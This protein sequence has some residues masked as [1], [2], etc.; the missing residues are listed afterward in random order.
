MF[1]A[2][3]TGAVAMIVTLW[4][5]PAVAGDP[6]IA[7][8]QLKIGYTL[9]QEGKCAEAVAHL[10][11]SLRLD[12]K[13]I[14]LINLADCEEKVGKL[15]D[16]LGH[17]VDARMRARTEGAGPIEEEAERRAT[18][19]EPRLARL[20]IVL[21]GAA[22]RDA[23]VE[24]D[25]VVLGAPSL[26]ISLPLDPGA[27]A[28]VVKAQGRSDGVT[29]LT[30]GEGESKRIEVDAGASVAKAPPPSAALAD[31][32]GASPSPLVFAGFGATAVG[33][34]VGAITGVAALNAGSDA[35]KACPVPTNC[36]AKTIDDVESGRT[37]GTVSTLAFVV[38]G[39]GAG[40][41]LY[42]LLAPRTDKR[43]KTA[44]TPPG[45]KLGLSLTPSF[46][47]VQGRF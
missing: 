22:P 35:E 38:A 31:D 28:V 15:A 37:L 3:R 25:G 2:V 11:E 8:E 41:G 17:W 19:L 46:V 9:A 33:L 10:S 42:G 14:T 18:A 36:N 39:V 45:T 34:V 44:G 13:A 5:L 47:S 24:R 23:I 4:P 16:A 40:V 26:G 43:P 30:L 7:R 1:R 21:A 20:T 6:V 29:Q 32:T 27:H 12:P